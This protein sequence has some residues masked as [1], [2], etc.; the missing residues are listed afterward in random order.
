M[1]TDTTTITVH[2]EF[3]PHDVA[4][5][6]TLLARPAPPV[7][8]FL[9]DQR[10]PRPVWEEMRAAGARYLSADDLEDMDMFRSDPGWRYSGAA[11][12]VLLQHGYV[13]R[14]Y[15]Q[16]I[17]TP[18]EF[19][20]LWTATAKAARREAAAQARQAAEQARQAA[21]QAAL[22]ERERKGANYQAWKAAHLAGLVYTTVAPEQARTPV[23]VPG[24]VSEW[25]QVAYFDPGTPGAWVDTGDRWYRKDVDGTP[26]YRCHY[27]SAW[28]WYAPQ[29]T[30]DAWI[31]SDEERRTPTARYALHALSIASKRVFGADRVRRILELRGQ[32]YYETMLRRAVSAGPELVFKRRD[33]TDTEY[34]GICDAHGIAY[35]VVDYTVVDYETSTRLR[36]YD[37]VPAG[38]TLY[39][40]E[41]GAVYWHHYTAGWHKFTVREQR[42]LDLLSPPIRL[43]A[44]D[45]Q[46]LDR[47]RSQLTK[48]KKADVAARAAER[49]IGVHASWT[50]DR[51]IQ[52]IMQKE[53]DARLDAQIRATLADA[54]AEEGA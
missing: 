50:K 6:D 45:Q 44:A 5:A 24:G 8:S 18:Q 27:G 12:N 28:I 14:V 30:V 13:L 20:A 29:E 48:H 49:G 46:E 32:D 19:A 3:E 37:L 25:D 34:R 21:E 39:R 31:L 15:D 11:I 35:T 26:V 52:E 42:A 23:V 54:D 16:E 47:L 36:Q 51:M 53:R 1:T 2:P 43:G 9:I 4:L 7:G 22:A 10:V 41:A 33:A 38:A 17:R 40:S